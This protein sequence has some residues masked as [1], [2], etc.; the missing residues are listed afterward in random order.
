M[1]IPSH[2]PLAWFPPQALV[3]LGEP[4]QVNARECTKVHRCDQ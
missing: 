2:S 3:P 4:R 1:T